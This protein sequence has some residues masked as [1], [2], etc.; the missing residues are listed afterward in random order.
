MPW[1]HTE[2]K[3]PAEGAFTLADVD[4]VRRETV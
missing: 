1:V 4:V 2:L 3:L